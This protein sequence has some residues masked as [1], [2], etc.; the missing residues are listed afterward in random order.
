MN[1]QESDKKTIKQL[2]PDP[3]KALSIDAIENAFSIALSELTKQGYDVDVHFLKLGTEI[4]HRD[5][6]MEI[7]VRKKTYLGD[8]PF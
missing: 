2:R 4:G 3:L 5:A 8:G 1:D 7:A 6:T